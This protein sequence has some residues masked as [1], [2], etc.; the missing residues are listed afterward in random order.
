M[1]E[2]IIYTAPTDYVMQNGSLTIS[3]THSTN[4]ISIPIIS[5]ALEEQDMECFIA[6][7]SSVS[8]D[9]ILAASVATIC[10]N[11]GIK[12]CLAYATLCI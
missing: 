3:K 4:C 7:F 1:I 5:D 2:M 9:F 12:I 10:I 6:S 11:E 8:S